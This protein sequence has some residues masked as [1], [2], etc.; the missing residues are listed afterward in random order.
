MEQEEWVK[1]VQ[2]PGFQLEDKH[3]D[4]TVLCI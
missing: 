1:G 4:K 3:V 2:G